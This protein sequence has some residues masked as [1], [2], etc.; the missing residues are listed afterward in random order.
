MKNLR[1][2]ACR[3][4]AMLLVLLLP[5][6]PALAAENARVLEITCRDVFREGT[7]QTVSILET[8]SGYFIT[9]E[10]AARMLGLRAMG[11]NYVTSN[12]HVMVTPDPGS[13]A[14]ITHEG[15]SWYALEALMTELDTAIFAA[16]GEIH[17]VSLPVNQDL[18]MEETQRIFSNG[19]YN[20]N[21][22]A[23]MP[24]AAFLTSFAFAFDVLWNQRFDMLTG[25]GYANDLS[26][27]LL[28][29]LN[30]Q[31]SDETLLEM[32]SVG[33]DLMERASSTV[34][35]AQKGYE[36]MYESAEIVV[37]GGGYLLFGIEGS[38]LLHELMEVGKA[39]DDAGIKLSDMLANAARIYG[40]GKIPG[41]Y[42]DALERVLDTAAARDYSDRTVI[43]AG[44]DVLDIYQAHLEDNRA[45]L[46][47]EGVLMTV[48]DIVFNLASDRLF[49][50]SPLGEIAKGVMEVA[51]ECPLNLFHN[52]YKKNDF[53]RNA[54]MCVTIQD[55]F[56]QVY[57]SENVRYPD[58]GAAMTMRDAAMLYVKTAWQAYEGA[59][60]DTEIAGAIRRV[61]GL[62]DQELVLLAGFPDGM[63]CVE[64][65]E[66]LP[67][68]ILSGYTGEAVR[69]DKQEPTEEN[70]QTT[71]DNKKTQEDSGD[72]RENGGGNYRELYMQFLRDGSYVEYIANSVIRSAYID[73]YA[74]NFYLFY[75]IDKDGTEDLV[76]WLG[77]TGADGE[78]MA[79][80][81]DGESVLYKGSVVC[82][83]I[84][85]HIFGTDGDT[86]MILA[87]YD[88]MGEYLIYCDVA[89]GTL[90]TI[91]YD[92]IL[93]MD[94]YLLSEEGQLP[95]IEV[96]EEEEETIQVP[97]EEVPE[98]SMDEC[99]EEYLRFLMD[100]SFIAYISNSVIR[101]ACSEAHANGTSFPDNYMVYHDMDWDGTVEM[102]LWLGCSPE[103]G[104]VLVFSYSGGEVHYVGS[105]A[106]DGSGTNILGS[107]DVTGVMLS[108]FA[109]YMES[110][111]YCDLAGGSLE[112]TRGYMI[113]DEQWSLLEE[114]GWLP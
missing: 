101:E 111:T 17:Y 51:D 42:S 60:F 27:I 75:D 109:G 69:Q 45:R 26:A 6:L 86:G 10:D 103:D 87:E 93:P 8:K 35:T 22:L 48:E 82:D 28:D 110:L 67:A 19:G 25:E 37:P 57:N 63:F 72:T 53:V 65:N 108:G 61:Q 32:L 4:L 18:L 20:A 13:A 83:G 68:G 46:A 34:L 92:T 77:C 23:D 91:V 38:G 11:G 99:R 105:V 100:R 54:A 7:E 95:R 3:M 70:K 9:L 44:E 15:K 14:R 2:F 1:R 39:Y 43:R 80:F 84:D 81:C 55:L 30:H 56:R 85:I 114:S 36:F 16:D 66:P 59:S 96:Q 58:A 107:G 24:G 49:K 41:M 98:F 33:T 88:G 112:I 113:H 31:G 97:P 5:A 94:W 90:K 78:V 21:M 73:G 76:I 47:A 71:Q 104:E 79:F 74:D 89:A 102:L 52:T 29:V 50:V 12:A 106:C 62:I 64:P 40:I